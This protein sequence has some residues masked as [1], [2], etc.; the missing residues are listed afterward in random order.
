MATLTSPT[1]GPDAPARTGPSFAAGREP[2]PAGGAAPPASP[3]DVELLDAYSRAVTDVVERVSPSV[4]FLEVTYGAA[5]GPDVRRRARPPQH[6]SGSG[7]VFTPDGLILTNS[8][9]VHGASG[10]EVTLAGHADP[11]PGAQPTPVGPRYRADLVGDD[12]DTDLAVVR[13]VAS[14][15]PAVTLGDS[16]A[17]RA[18]QLVVAIGNPLGFQTT[19]T[20][21]VVSALGRSLRSQSGRLMDDLIQTDAPL[22]PGNSGG[23][24]VD[25]RGRVVGVCTAT[26]LP[27]Q[28]LCFA[29]PVHTAEFVAGRLIRDGRIRRGYLG[30]GGQNV[31]LPRRLARLSGRGSPGGVLVVTVEPDSPA[32]RAGLRE[33]DIT[34]GFAGRPVTSVDD[35]HRLL[36]EDVIGVTAGIDLFRDLAPLALSITPV[37]SRPAT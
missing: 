20:A 9:V 26:I 21:G 23:P 35:L 17:L 25:S 36:T 11:D 12:P 29:I 2:R 10:I 1:S 30:I 18:G 16:R 27:A 6:G 22:N 28:G 3:S 19:V 34:A 33:R 8:H 5:P 32:A 4:A 14:G 24:L 37:E 15:L 31:T 7:F 13:I